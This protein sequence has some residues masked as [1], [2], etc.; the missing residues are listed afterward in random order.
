MK[1]ISKKALGIITLVIIC[2]GIMAV[3]E[4]I[5]EP[6]YALKSAIKIILFLFIPLIFLKTQ[7][8]VSI[9]NAFILNKKDIGRLLILGF[10][11]Y[12]VIMVAYLL[13]KN[14]FDYS[15]LISSLSADQQVSNKSFIWVAAYISLCN[16]LLEEFAFRFVSFIALSK[17]TSKKI[18]FIFS[19]VAFAVYHVAMFASSFPLPLI[20]LSLVGLTSGGMIF[21]YVDDKNK[22]IYNSWIIHMFADFAIMTIWYIHI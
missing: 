16:S 20:I 13:T 7:K 14:I 11:I 21:N 5:V 12:A 17:Y 1:A 18:A 2:C 15:S 19:S 22:T 6:T 4:T 3:I 8:A 10:A 9:K